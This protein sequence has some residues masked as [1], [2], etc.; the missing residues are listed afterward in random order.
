MR[1]LRVYGPYFTLTEPI[2]T[3]MPNADVSTATLARFSYRLPMARQTE[4]QFDLAVI[5]ATAANTNHQDGNVFVQATAR[6]IFC[7]GSINGG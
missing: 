3:F 4:R 2:G 1:I 6:A 5:M 7:W